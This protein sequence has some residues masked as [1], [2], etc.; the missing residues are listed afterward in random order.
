MAIWG[1]WVPPSELHKETMIPVDTEQRR[2]H[3]TRL[4]CH[5]N[6][7]CC[8]HTCSS[9]ALS[10]ILQAAAS[11]SSSSFS[12]SSSSSRVRQNGLLTLSRFASLPVFALRLCSAD[13]GAVTWCWLHQ[14][15]WPFG[16]GGKGSVL[17]RKINQQQVNE[18]VKN[19]FKKNKNVLTYLLRIS[20]TICSFQRNFLIRWT[21]QFQPVSLVLSKYSNLKKKCWFHPC[22]AAALLIFWP[23]TS[24]VHLAGLQ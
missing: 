17:R 10:S 9:S 13:P 22:L 7:S 24:P 5:W 15:V 2:R 21:L 11:Y 1:K 3:Q 8:P 23:V 14:S 6:Q 12:S 18:A 19:D 16:G 20:F 4:W